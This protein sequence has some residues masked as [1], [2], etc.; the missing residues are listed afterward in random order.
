MTLRF[1]AARPAALHGPLARART[2]RITTLPANDNGDADIRYSV[3]RAALRH[4]ALHGLAAAG[5]ARDRA[6]QAHF[7]GDRAGY[8]HWLAVC[9]A[10]NRRMAEALAANLARHK[11]PRQP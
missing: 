7:A 1:A 6:R 3:L 5:D 4:F 10:L 2:V 9:R 11:P 8:C